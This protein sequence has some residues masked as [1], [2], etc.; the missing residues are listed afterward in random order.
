L[1]IKP[2]ASWGI[3]TGE[4]VSAFTESVDIMPT[5]LEGIG[6]NIPRQCNGK[7][8]LPLLNG[9]LPADWRDAVHWLFDFRDPLQGRSEAHFQMPSSDCNVLV[10][11]DADFKYVHF[12]NLPPLLFDMRNDP[13]ESLNLAEEPDYQAVV[14]HYTQKLLSWRMRH[15]YSELDNLIASDDG[16]TEKGD[17]IT[18]L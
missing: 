15:E 13:Q 8:L 12:A 1:I 17:V 16:L 5:I 2:P 6:R 11:R 7:S 10:H 14:L 9:E 4:T 3:N 18:E